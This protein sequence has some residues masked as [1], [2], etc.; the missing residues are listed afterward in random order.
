MLAEIDHT[1]DNV[2][3]VLRWQCGKWGP[4]QAVV[5][6]GAVGAVLPAALVLGAVRRWRRSR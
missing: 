5:V 2:R 6:A 1:L 3:R 4:G